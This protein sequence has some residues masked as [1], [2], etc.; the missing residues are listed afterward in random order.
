MWL[1]I[2]KFKW[3]FAWFPSNDIT[4]MHR[5][6]RNKSWLDEF[7][8]QFTHDDAASWMFLEMFLSVHHFFPLFSQKADIWAD[9]FFRLVSWFV[10]LL[11]RDKLG[12]DLCRLK[13]QVDNIYVNPDCCA[14][15]FP[16]QCRHLH[17]FA[18]T[19][20]CVH[21]HLLF[22]FKHQPSMLTITL[23]EIFQKPS[24]NLVVTIFVL[25]QTLPISACKILAI[26]TA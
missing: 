18:C 21:D 16:I 3:I 25:R 20:I 7:Q 17:I 24:T 13:H 23:R 1:A 26:E 11:T 12:L 4:T 6:L 14:F 15:C 10:A 22:I 5:T 8:W 9:L 2:S 19:G